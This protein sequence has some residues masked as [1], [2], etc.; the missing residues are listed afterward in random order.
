VNVRPRLGG[1]PAVTGASLM[2]TGATIAVE[3]LVA[4][5]VTADVEV[6][7]EVVTAVLVTGVDEQLPRI[8]AI[9]T[10]MIARL[11]RIFFNLL[12]PY[13]FIS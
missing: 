6:I 11:N 10:R 4:V 8:V 7:V 13:Y 1:G 5:V 12:T 2:I 9:N 3:V